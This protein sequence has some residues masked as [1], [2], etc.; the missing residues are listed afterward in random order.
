M[1]EFIHFYQTSE[2]KFY[3]YRFYGCFLKT[4]INTWN[5]KEFLTEVEATNFTKKNNISGPTTLIPI[6]NIF[7]KVFD[8]YFIHR[9]INNLTKIN[10]DSIN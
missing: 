3:T 7:P 2:P 10:I 1:I 5:C 6:D 4:S 8:K 9:Q